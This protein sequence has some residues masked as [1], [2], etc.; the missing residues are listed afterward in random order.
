MC[1]FFTHPDL[2]L[3]EPFVEFPESE[4]NSPSR[5]VS[6]RQYYLCTK[7]NITIT[8]CGKIVN[9]S[10]TDPDRS[11]RNFERIDTK[12]QTTQSPSFVLV[13]HGLLSWPLLARVSNFRRLFQS[14]TSEGAEGSDQSVSGWVQVG[15][16][17]YVL[18]VLTTQSLCPCGKREELW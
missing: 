13:L 11:Q 10:H 12:V 3:L 16:R 17:R 6:R 8:N 7:T 5:N 15:T 18:V 2:T 1:N 14:P 9:L 4:I